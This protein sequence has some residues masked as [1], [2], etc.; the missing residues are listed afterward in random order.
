MTNADA[1]H[2]VMVTDPSQNPPTEIDFSCDIV[3]A[4]N[5]FKGQTSLKV[6]PDK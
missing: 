3:V 1:D 2:Q 4:V 5:E 6:T